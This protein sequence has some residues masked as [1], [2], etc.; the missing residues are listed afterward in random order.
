MGRVG[1]MFWGQGEMRQNCVY[2]TLLCLICVIIN[3]IKK[4]KSSDFKFCSFHYI[5][6]WFGFRNQVGFL[7]YFQLN[8]IRVAS[9]SHQLVKI[10]PEVLSHQS[11]QRQKSPTESIKACVAIIGISTSFHTHVSFWT[12]AVNVAKKSIIRSSAVF[13]FW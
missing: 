6:V 1:N 7:I 3:K 11:K 8:T 10:F 12:L 4:V 5:M 2:N 9:G 13:S